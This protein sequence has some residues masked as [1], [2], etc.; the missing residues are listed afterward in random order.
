PC[1]DRARLGPRR[2]ATRRIGD[3]RAVKRASSRPRRL[4]PVAT[5]CS[6]RPPHREAL[7]V[8]LLEPSIR[9]VAPKSLSRDQATKP[10]ELPPET[11]ARR[12]WHCS[13]NHGR[14]TTTLKLPDRPRGP[15]ASRGRSG[16][17]RYFYSALAFCELT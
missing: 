17:N 16:G 2:S 12:R 3:T 14:A 15:A 8:S 1:G 4:V 5:D 13:N 10:I 11:A 6:P 7:L 9:N